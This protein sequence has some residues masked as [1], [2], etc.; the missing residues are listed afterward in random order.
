MPDAF[1]EDQQ[2][3]YDFRSSMHYNSDAFLTK[4]AKEA[5][6]F[7]ITKKEN[8]EAIFP[9]ARRLSSIDTVQ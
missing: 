9:A 3:P 7:S 8:A 6:L 1:W 2:E 5:G 4:D